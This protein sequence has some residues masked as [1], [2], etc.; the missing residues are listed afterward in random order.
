[1]DT[2]LLW[3]IAAWVGYFTMHSLLASLAVKNRVARRWPQLMPW[4]RLFF[5]AMAILLLAAPLYLAWAIGGEIIIAWKGIWWWVGN[6]LALAALGGFVYS[7]RHYDGA[8]FLGLRQ[9][10]DGEQRVE[11]QE[12]FRISPLHQQVRHPW[13]FLA[14]VLI[15]TRDM[16]AAM[17]VSSVMMTL[18]FVLGSWLEER[19]LLAYY[20]DA[21][22]EYRQLVPGLL[23]RPWKRLNREQAQTLERRGNAS[24]LHRN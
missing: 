13:Y 10:R 12:R 3:L 14:L 7:L 4:Y 1:M 11:D 17:L 15:W 9:L 5:N 16:T 6:G 8:E 20:G 19:K 22:R 24:V 23:P 21:Y 2:A 18:Y